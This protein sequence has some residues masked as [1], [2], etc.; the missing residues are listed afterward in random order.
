MVRQLKVIGFAL[1]GILAIN[2]VSAST[3]SAATIQWHSA[4][5][6]TT[7]WFSSNTTQIVWAF[8]GGSIKCKKG[9]SVSTTGSSTTSELTTTTTESECTA[10]GVAGS[11]NMNGCTETLTEPTLSGG[12]YQ[13]TTHIT[14]PAGKKIV[15][16]VP[17]G[18]CSIE[19]G[20]Q[21]PGG[22][23]DL[24]NEGAGETRDLLVT[25]T[26]NGIAYTV[27]GPGFI[28]GALG[29]SANGTYT[30]SSTLK[31]FKN[32]AHTEQAGVWVE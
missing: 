22:V 19:I 2:V 5:A 31:G 24:K 23:L 30:G 21:T 15:I 6:T 16:S 12:N 7:H 9:T 20:A 4:I 28:C 27:V 14:C 1:L 8:T 3:A 29:A 13:V 10:F 18:N 17:A 26:L 25:S 32:E 11:V